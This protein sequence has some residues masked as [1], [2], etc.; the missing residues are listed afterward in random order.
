[1]ML[2]ATRIGSQGYQVLLDYRLSGGICSIYGNGIGGFHALGFTIDVAR[3]PSGHPT[4]LTAD[5]PRHVRR[6]DLRGQANSPALRRDTR[7]V[8][9]HLEVRRLEPLPDLLR[10]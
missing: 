5:D 7:G 8:P 2:R 9:R 3:D 4:G 10:R 1:M 6:T